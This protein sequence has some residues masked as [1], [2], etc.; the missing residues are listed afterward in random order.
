MCIT[1]EE[2]AGVVMCFCS[3]R[4]NSCS[5]VRLDSSM[6]RSFCRRLSTS[7]AGFLRFFFFCGG[8]FHGGGD[9]RRK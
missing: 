2:L 6:A 9:G 3:A 8:G 5:S 1:A 4:L 7:K